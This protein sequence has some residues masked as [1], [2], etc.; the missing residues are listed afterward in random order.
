[1]KLSEIIQSIRPASFAEKSVAR[2]AGVSGGI[3]VTLPYI[4]AGWINAADSQYTQ[5]APHTIIAGVRTQITIDGLGASTNI[6]YANGMHLD[7]WSGNVFR[8]AALGEAYI[9]RLTSI[10][11]QTN[12]GSGAYITFEIDIGTPG[13]QFIA[14]AQGIPL[15]KGQGVATQLTIS[16]PLFC[17]DTFGLNGAKLYITPSVDITMWNAAIF[18]QRTFK[19]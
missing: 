19:P 14:A 6:A 12:S 7:V 9:V 3:D 8:P 13:V 17:L 10:I 18:V 16:E 4:Q 2:V 11:A 1:M 15:L 5:G